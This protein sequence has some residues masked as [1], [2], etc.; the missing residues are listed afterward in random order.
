MYGNHE[1]GPGHLSARTLGNV[2]SGSGSRAECPSWVAPGAGDGP[3]PGNGVLY[4]SPP[5][6][7][8]FHHQPRGH[9]NHRGARGPFC[10]IHLGMD[11]GVGVTT[12]MRPRAT[13]ADVSTLQNPFMVTSSIHETTSVDVLTAGRTLH[14]H[15]II[16]SSPHAPHWSAREGLY[17]K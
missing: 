6:L 4:C 9:G 2:V 14:H 13:Q 10:F 17:G 8:R 11:A 15:A 16:Q 5:G 7:D 1:I 12:D 3:S